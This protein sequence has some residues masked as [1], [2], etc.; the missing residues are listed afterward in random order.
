M[1]FSYKSTYGYAFIHQAKYAAADTTLEK[2]RWCWEK[3]SV[4]VDVGT[5][6]IEGIVFSQKGYWVDITSSHDVDARM[7]QPDGEPLLLKIKV[8]LQRIYPWLEFIYLH[9]V[10]VGQL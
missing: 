1:C 4:N 2:D 9:F 8:V 7:I 5:E 3:S 10:V 6:D